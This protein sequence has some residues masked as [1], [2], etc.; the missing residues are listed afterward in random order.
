M[1]LLLLRCSS[2]TGVDAEVSWHIDTVRVV[3]DNFALVL[4]LLLMLLLL[5]LSPAHL[6]NAVA[7]VVDV[8][9]LLGVAH[10]HHQLLLPNLPLHHP[11]AL[12]LQLKPE[13]TAA[14]AAAAAAGPSFFGIDS[15]DQCLDIAECQ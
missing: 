8:H 6:H 1:L 5:L 15:S 11:L 7:A 4:L 10:C 9:A 12:L 3:L 2:S 14:A 13:A